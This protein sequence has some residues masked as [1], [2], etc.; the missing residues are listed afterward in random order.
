MAEQLQKEKRWIDEIYM[1]HENE[2]WL[3]EQ[4]QKGFILKSFDN[5]YATFLKGNP[6]DRSYK[7]SILD[8]EKA[9]EQI[10]I[11]ENQGFT[12]TTKFKEYYIFH[13]DGKNTNKQLQL[14]NEII[15]FTIKWFDKQIKRQF[16]VI[17]FLIPFIILCY[18]VARCVGFYGRAIVVDILYRI[19]TIWF[20]LYGSILALIFIKIINE[21]LTLR[22]S[23]KFFLEKNK[24]LSIRNSIESKIIRT[25][26]IYFLIFLMFII[27]PSMYLYMNYINEKEVVP[28]SEVYES[29]PIVLIQDIEQEDHKSSKLMEAQKQVGE[30]N[31][32]ELGSNLFAQ[33]QYYSFQDYEYQDKLKSFMSIRYYET[34]ST[35]LAKISVKELA[36]ANAYRKERIK[37][38][39]YNGFDQVY[40]YAVPYDTLVAVCKGKEVM[41]IEYGG[42]QPVSKILN[43]M[44]EVL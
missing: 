24:Y 39:K 43:E 23:K 4:V 8:E 44:S 11:I 3:N 2:M 34:A 26:N 14:N 32:A 1:L 22:K 29:M 31:H 37:K 30:F 36:F 25:I 13:R 41:V 9:E 10:K 5:K 40:I 27:Y 19:P 18:I 33:K 17:E 6:E 38:I 15:E 42:D 7:I 20:I 12:F 21:V 35:I 16:S 28:I